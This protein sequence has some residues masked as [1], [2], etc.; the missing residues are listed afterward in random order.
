MDQTRQESA[1]TK[2]TRLEHFPAQP[3]VALFSFMQEVDAEETVTTRQ[4][5]HSLKL[6]QYTID[7]NHKV[8]TNTMSFISIWKMTQWL[9]QLGSS[10]GCEI[11]FEGDFKAN[12]MLRF[13]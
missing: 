13:S 1:A 9:T 10:K 6:L 12:Q 7:K 4:F 5:D 3:T 11:K 8:F 2:I